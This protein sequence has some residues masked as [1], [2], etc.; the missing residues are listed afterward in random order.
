MTDASETASDQGSSEA[1]CR[2]HGGDP[3]YRAY[4][5]REWGRPVGD[6]RRLFEKLCLE[7]F[8]AGLA[9]IT[10][11]RKRE[12]FREAFEGFEI[13][14][15]A[16]FDD[17]DVARLLGNAGIVRHEGKIRSVINNARRTQA[18]VESEGS[19]ARFV[20][21]YEPAPA[22]RPDAVT[23]EVLVT[24]TTCPEAVALSK[25]LKKRGFSFVGPTTVY[26]F[27]QSM[28]LVNDHLEGCD[29]RAACERDRQAFRRP[30]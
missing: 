29:M 10:I 19:L 21:G 4:H 16:R 3:L 30:A 15:V 13:D 24:M 7:G 17:D 26:A 2:W 6:D 18:L 25:A 1:T 23:P 27:M 22:A 9:W 12:N 5:D 8:Q 28:G 20:W 11:L 14:R